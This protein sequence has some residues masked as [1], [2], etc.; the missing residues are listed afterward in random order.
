MI[1]LTLKIRLT[2][3]QIIVLVSAVVKVLSYL[4]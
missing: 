3:P 2:V 4:I 1:E